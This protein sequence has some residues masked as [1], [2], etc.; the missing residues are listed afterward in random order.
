M[1]IRVGQPFSRAQLNAEY[2]VT[3]R[4]ETLA[5]R[6]PKSGHYSRLERDAK[7]EAIWISQT[8]GNRITFDH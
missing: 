3:W 7:N 1:Q 5:V 6:D 8:T 2:T 4:R